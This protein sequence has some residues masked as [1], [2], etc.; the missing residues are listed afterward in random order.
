MYKC[1]FLALFDALF[2]VTQKP[3]EFVYIYQGR[4]F[5]AIIVDMCFKQAEGI[6]IVQTVFKPYIN[7]I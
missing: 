5:Y 4:G 7:Q 2:I 1:L 6:I 3:I